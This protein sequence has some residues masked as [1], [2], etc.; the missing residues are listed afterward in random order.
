MLLLNTKGLPKTMHTY[1][2]STCCLCL[3]YSVYTLESPAADSLMTSCKQNAVTSGMLYPVM[4]GRLPAAVMKDRS[5]FSAK[6]SALAASE[7][8]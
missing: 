6:P 2:H 5:G 8:S 7:C 3:L 4:P 1:A